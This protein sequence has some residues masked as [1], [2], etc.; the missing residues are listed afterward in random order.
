MSSTVVCPDAGENLGSLLC[1][2][3]PVPRADFLAH[4]AAKQPVVPSPEHVV[5]QITAVLNGEITD[6]SPGI[7]DE[8]L[9]KG[10]CRTSLKARGARSAM[11][12]VKGVVIVKFDITQ[13][14]SEEKVAA[15]FFV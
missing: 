9:W 13:Q 12:R 3:R 6:A 15:E 8:W 14:G 2:A 1:G 11:F 4:I 7:H 10:V 5:G